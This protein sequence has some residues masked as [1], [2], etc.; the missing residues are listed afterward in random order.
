[1]SN[2]MPPKTPAGVKP[3]APSQ[4]EAPPSHMPPSHPDAARTAPRGTPLAPRVPGLA[5]DTA[6]HPHV[7]N[8]PAAPGKRK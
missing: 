5:A 7:A 1:M 2:P 3:T 6:K 8:S 4:V